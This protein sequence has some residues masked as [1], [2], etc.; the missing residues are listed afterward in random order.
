MTDMIICLLIVIVCTAASAVLVLLSRRSTNEALREL[1]RLTAE[2]EC[3]RNE[4]AMELRSEIS[5]NREHNEALRREMRAE[6][7]QCHCK[8]DEL[9][10]MITA[11]DCLERKA[12]EQIDA[13]NQ[14]ILN[15]L[16]Y[17]GGKKAVRTNEEAE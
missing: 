3:G 5:E 7:E 17:D 2:W 9:R 15:I 1:D 13:F 6:L 8:V 16:S 10:K 14:G 11:D 12:K 4:A